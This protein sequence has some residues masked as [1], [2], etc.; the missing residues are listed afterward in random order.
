MA[1]FST[2]SSHR[3]ATGVALAWALCACRGAEPHGPAASPAHAAPAPSIATPR[4]QLEIQEEVSALRGLAFERPIPYEEQTRAQFRGVVR[5][6]LARDI[7]A[8]KGSALSRTYSRMGFVPSNFDL[9]AALEEAFTTQVLAYYDPRTHVF[10]VLDRKR[11][12]HAKSA[13][14]DEVIA[15]ELV[16]ALQ[17]QHFD[18]MAYNGEGK[19]QPDL[20]DDART[21]RRFVTEGEATFLQMAWQ[22]GSGSGAKKSLGPFTLAGLRMGVAMLAA[23][24]LVELLSAMRHGHEADS[25]PP[26]ERAAI[27]ATARLPPVIIVPMVEP[28]Y[29]GALFISDA[30]A[31][32]G[33]A[34]VDDLYRH[35]PESTEQALHPVEKFLDHRDPPVRISLTGESAVL[36]GARL[37]TSDVLG[38]LGLRIYF[39]TCQYA[40]SD[41]AA[42]G[43]GG[44]RYW[45]WQLHGR[46]VVA[47]ATR[48]DSA[49]AA[50]RFLAAYTA[51][52]AQRFPRATMQS[53]RALVEARTRSAADVRALTRPDGGLVAVAHRD[54]DVDIVDGA[55]AEDTPALLETLRKASRQTR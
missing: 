48:W 1:R 15:H 23:A 54:L 16:H 9:N 53:E 46:H 47:T 2:N 8:E 4:W 19:N 39:K 14:G 11:A 10:R 31:R 17:D 38:E 21:A 7:P 28:Y 30:W 12:P 35:P 20:D 34:A 45:S 37:L 3:F 25:L 33:W 40:D 36:A 32:G 26:D 50:A 55:S 29:K 49:G 43:W 22:M 6:D 41:A 27:E 52:L 18:L 51:T 24:D 5:D 13:S 44:D 42:A